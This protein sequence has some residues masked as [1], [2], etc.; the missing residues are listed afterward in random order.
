[1]LPQGQIDLAEEADSV[2]LPIPAYRTAVLGLFRA[3]APTEVPRWCEL[4][5]AERGRLRQ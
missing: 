2:K 4:G 5:S 1:M 3:L